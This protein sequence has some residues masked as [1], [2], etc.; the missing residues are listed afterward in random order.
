[1]SRQ[2]LVFTGRQVL[3]MLAVLVPGWPGDLGGVLSGVPGGLLVG[4]PG[5][6]SAAGLPDGGSGGIRGA[7]R[8]S[9]GVPRRVA[10]AAIASS[11]SALMLVGGV[12]GAEPGDR[13]AVLC[14]GGELAYPGG[15]GGGHAGDRAVRLGVVSPGGARRLL[16]WHRH[17][18][19]GPCC[20]RRR[21]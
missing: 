19:R 8:V 21:R 16:S 4:W 18:R 5:G 10:S 14:L 12:A 6:Q 7:G 13:A 15:D 9:A 17:R 1:M 20:R 3:V 2:C 11:S